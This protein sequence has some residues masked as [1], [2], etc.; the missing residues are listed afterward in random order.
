MLADLA[1]VEA[2]DQRFE[3]SLA[4]YRAAIDA[5][6]EAGS[7]LAVLHDRQNMACTL[8]MMGRL[9]DA[10]EL[11][12]Q[13]IPRLVQFADPNWLIGFAEDYGAV[14][15][16]LGDSKLATRLLGSADAMR[17]RRGTPRSPVQEA[18]IS[19]AFDTARASLT[20]E[21]WSREY[22]WGVR[23]PVEDSLTYAY[24]GRSHNSQN[25]PQHS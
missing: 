8:R 17:E 19:P 15:A 5:H 23:R 4:L 14:L 9:E 1:F 3:R 18:E 12:W 13:Q 10:D 6:Q 20:P 7:E 16:E 21:A 11:L 25:R 2:V 24:S 22:R